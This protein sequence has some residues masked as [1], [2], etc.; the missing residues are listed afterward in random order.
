MTHFPSI[1]PGAS[2]LDVVAR[3]HGAVG[4]MMQ[5]FAA[6][7]DGPSELSSGERELLA[8]YTSALNRCTYCTRSH[9]GAALAHGIDEALVARVIEGDLSSLR[10]NLA[11]VFSL[12]RRASLS[13]HEV[14][15]ADI[16]AV[17]AAG[18]TEQTALDTL[19]VVSVFAFINRVAS[20]SGL[21]LTEHQ[22]REVGK[23]IATRGYAA[24]GRR[25][26]SAAE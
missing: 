5:I 10:P 24:A 15:P 23:F 4:P 16:S 26:T 19:F 2:V 3:F 17:I 25:F 6:A 21:T 7:M 14:A 22:G 9:A 12:A 1:T 11:P 8:T 18:W 13:P 20:A